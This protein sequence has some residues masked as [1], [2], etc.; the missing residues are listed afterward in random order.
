MVLMVVV[1]PQRARAVDLEG[2]LSV[3]KSAAC[4]EGWLAETSVLQLTGPIAF[5]ESVGQK[6]KSHLFTLKNYFIQ[7]R[8][9]VDP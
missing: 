7:V 2:S 6:K 3:V 1:R 5:S 4:S 8:V 9:T